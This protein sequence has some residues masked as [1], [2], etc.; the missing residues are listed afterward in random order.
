MH[1]EVQS[2]LPR[3]L[4][5]SLPQVWTRAC[6]VF[7]CS[8]EDVLSVSRSFYFLWFLLTPFSYFYTDSDSRGNKNVSIHPVLSMSLWVSM[9]HYITH[10]TELVSHL[11]A[12]THRLDSVIVFSPDDRQ[13]CFFPDPICLFAGAQLHFC[14][15]F[16]LSKS[17]TK[18]SL[19]LLDKNS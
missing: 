3:W 15:H 6:L 19:L 4:S 1:P 12:K 18:G 16:W 9:K 8:L 10:I 13:L 5:E 14:S 11:C 17:I 7:Q 2:L